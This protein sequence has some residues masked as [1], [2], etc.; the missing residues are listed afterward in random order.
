MYSQ[1]DKQQSYIDRLQDAELVVMIN[2]L[3]PCFA[4]ATGYNRLPL[5][6]QAPDWPQTITDFP[7]EIYT[8]P[9]AFED[10]MKDALGDWMPLI[11]RE[12]DE[13][14]LLETYNQ[15]TAAIPLLK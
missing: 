14:V 5:A 11:E 8:N 3:V 13:N 6:D 2:S 10:F 7:E 15:I 12:A 4:D 9:Q 1:D